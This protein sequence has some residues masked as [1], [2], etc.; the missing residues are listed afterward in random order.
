MS[1]FAG[2]GSVSLREGDEQIWRRGGGG[3]VEEG[4]LGKW[5]GKSGP[6]SRFVRWGRAI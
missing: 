6:M 2:G 5:C 4:K 3:E 1:R